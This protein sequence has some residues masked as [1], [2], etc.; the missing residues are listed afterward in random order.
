MHGRR[1]WSCFLALVGGT[2]LVGCA[3]AAAPAGNDSG[4]G[5]ELWPERAWRQ[6]D[7]DVWIDG[8]LA[9]GV[10]CYRDREAGLLLLSATSWPRWPVIAQQDGQASA[11][12][13]ASAA[14]ERA[15][16]ESRR[17]AP[18]EVSRLGPVATPAPGQFLLA[19]RGRTVLVMP[20]QGL[21]GPIDPP[22]L[23]ERMAGWRRRGQHYEPESR[24][25]AALAR[26]ERPVTLEITF[27]T[28]CSDS[29]REVPALLRTLELAANE[30]IA[31]KLV[32]VTRDFARPEG[33]AQLRGITNVP[34]VRVIE[35]GEE[36]GRFVESP[37]GGSA[38]ED[39]AAILEGRRPQPPAT[40][41]RI[42]GSAVLGSVAGP[43][44]EEHLVIE[45][46]DGGR[47]SIRSRLP[48]RE[49]EI[50]LHL[51]GV[52]RPGSFQ[53]TWGSDPEA[54]RLRGWR[55]GKRLEARVRGRSVGVQRQSTFLPSGSLVLLPSV[56]TQAAAL[57]AAAAPEWCY[58][59]G[60][61]T[62][63]LGVQHADIRL[64]D[65]GRQTVR[66]PAGTFNARHLRL[67]R[68]DGSSDWWLH[69]RLPLLL[70]HRSSD[71]RVIEALDLDTA[72]E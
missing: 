52:R 43:D 48:R 39:L 19:W 37:V 21:A 3:P 56:G 41:R 53:V 45:Q 61:A 67:N 13:C 16:K 59:V 22:S 11:L 55:E 9:G 58:R 71:G 47:L 63:P 64:E 7:R 72:R 36:I 68:G 12:E 33:W 28:W 8:R 35:G 32:A 5:P 30:R 49:V 18:R 46:D 51:D 10:S 1:W 40:S 69:P 14:T 57:G 70:R 17:T 54:V 29:R 4:P 50:V 26:L 66:V 65:L 25:L 23:F 62:A 42:V 31:V 6:V 38:E 20:H 24:A 34:T 44:E 27:G 2:M 60:N 15:W